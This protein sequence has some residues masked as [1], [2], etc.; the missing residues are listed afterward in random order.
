MVI[1]SA[2]EHLIV[3][4]PLARPRRRR[5]GQWVASFCILLVCAGVVAHLLANPPDRALPARTP[6]EWLHSYSI[7]SRRA[8]RLISLTDH[9]TSAVLR[10]ELHAGR[11]QTISL[12]QHDGLWRPVRTSR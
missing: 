9:G 3:E 10:V 8:F 2:S 6:A 4:E 1:S 12:Q 5:T 11:T 7:A